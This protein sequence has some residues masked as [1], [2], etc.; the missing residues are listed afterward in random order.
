MQ[1]ATS[2]SGNSN[3]AR[4]I[5][6]GAFLLVVLL[7]TG[8]DATA[9]TTR[10]SASSQAAQLSRQSWDHLRN[11]NRAD[12]LSSMR[13]LNSLVGQNQDLFTPRERTDAAALLERLEKPTY[14]SSNDALAKYFSKRA[15]SIDPLGDYRMERTRFLRPVVN[16]TSFRSVA[17]L[18]RR[19]RFGRPI[20]VRV[21]VHVKSF[22]SDFSQGAKYPTTHFAAEKNESPRSA[23]NISTIDEWLATPSE[24]RVFVT[25]ARSDRHYVDTLRKRYRDEGYVLFFYLDCKPLCRTS[26]VGSFFGTAGAAIHIE[27]PE[28]AKSPYVPIEVAITKNLTGLGRPLNLID[29]NSPTGVSLYVF[30]PAMALNG[31]QL[32]GL[33]ALKLECSISD[34]QKLPSASACLS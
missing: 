18:A 23:R 32:L 19:W 1:R 20:E 5:L 34:Q 2:D 3:L 9:R 4:R 11:G 22:A 31:V 33:D 27:S 15:T 21:S 25:G 12:A 28:S 17:D 13:A 29:E 16:S 8:F 26:T 7:W 14:F 10:A 6:T 24:K 30:D